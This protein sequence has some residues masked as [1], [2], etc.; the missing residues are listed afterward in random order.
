LRDISNG[1]IIRWKLH[2]Q[3]MPNLSLGIL[4]I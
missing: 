3:G 1:H 4:T 2:K